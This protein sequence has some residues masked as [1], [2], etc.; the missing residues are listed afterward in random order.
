MNLKESI[1]RIIRE[2]SIVSVGTLIKT[3]YNKI[4]KQGGLNFHGIKLIPNLVDDTIEF[5]MD[6]ENDLSYSKQ[7]LT[8]YVN[9]KFLK[10][11]RLF[12]ASSFTH[13]IIYSRVLKI[14]N[15]EDIYLNNKD[16]RMVYELLHQKKPI[17]YVDDYKLVS[18]ISKIKEFWLKSHD[19]LIELIVDCEFTNHRLINRETEEIEEEFND[20][21]LDEF[22][23]TWDLKGRY[24]N[25]H[26]T[27]TMFDPA[28]DYLWNINTL[29]N[30]D[31][32]SIGSVVHGYYY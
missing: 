10:F 8:Y 14:N 13:Q 18:D 30:Q 17:L 3:F 31:D 24:L 25:D 29:I 11:I 21:Q 1:R 12:G 2:E 6:N 32:M 16:T 27:D 28:L 20:K 9:N 7:A 15:A 26:M 19:V 4:S 22:L 5:E 23:K